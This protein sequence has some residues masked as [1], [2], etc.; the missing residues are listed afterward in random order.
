MKTVIHFF[1]GWGC[2]SR[3]WDPLVHLLHS[4]R[5]PSDST[6][7]MHNRGYFNTETEYSSDKDIFDQKDNHILISHSLGCFCI[8][9][10]LLQIASQWII[11][12]GFRRFHD[13]NEA[14]SRRSLKKMMESFKIN[15]A[16]VLQTFHKRMMYPNDNQENIQ[17]LSSEAATL[18]SNQL[19]NDLKLL[20]AGI[21]EAKSASQI[22]K[23]VIFHGDNDVIVHVEHAAKLAS[24]LNA[25]TQ[26]ISN[27]GHG[28]PYTHPSLILSVV[29]FT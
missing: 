18:N 16:G 19:L 14:Y 25:S 6:I 15:P 5:N 4:R 22:R 13:V 20:D 23:V 24:H 29:H 11:I 27:G 1:H 12:S 2:D 21:L 26:L 28:I 10:Y 7:I 3:I 17:R 9:D 8:P